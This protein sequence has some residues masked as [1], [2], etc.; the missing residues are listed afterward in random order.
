MKNTFS[1]ARG[2]YWIVIA[3]AA[4]TFATHAVQGARLM[5]EPPEPSVKQQAAKPQPAATSEASTIDLLY[6][7]AYR[8]GLY[9]GKLAAQ[10][11]EQ[12]PAPVGRWATQS[13]REAFLEG[14]EQSSAEV[15]EARTL[16]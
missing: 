16:N 15:A 10:R 5:K 8:D 7:A 6:R 14:Y 4:L 1:K 13:D 9:V 3:A 2:A 11:G 12:R